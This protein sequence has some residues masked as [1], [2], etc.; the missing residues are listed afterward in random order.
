MH[1]DTVK[2]FGDPTFLVFI[3]ISL[4][5][6]KQKNQASWDGSSLEQIIYF[7][8]TKLKNPVFYN[9]PVRI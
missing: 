2:R 1:G 3:L 8:A 5:N 9:I 6:W 7:L 4:T